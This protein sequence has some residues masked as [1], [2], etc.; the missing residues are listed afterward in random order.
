VVG[1]YY[2]KDCDKPL[3]LEERKMII[4]EDQF[5]VKE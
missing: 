2:S 5:I 1:T 3:L 4:D